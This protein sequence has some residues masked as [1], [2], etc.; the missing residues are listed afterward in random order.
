M[1]VQMIELEEV[2]MFEISDDALEGETNTFADNTY[3]SIGYPTA[4]C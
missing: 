4:E 2:I 3:N 1:P